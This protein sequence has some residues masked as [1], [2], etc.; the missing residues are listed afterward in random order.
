MQSHE[1][2]LRIKKYTFGDLPAAF[3][4]KV[5]TASPTGQEIAHWHSQVELIRVLDGHIHCH[6]NHSEFRLGP[7][8][9]CFINLGQL[10]RVYNTE[11]Q[12]CA[13]EVLAVSP[14]LLSQNQKV[15]DAYISPVISDGSCGSGGR[16][17]SRR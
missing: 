10:H 13:L 3:E 1:K 15:F 4:H 8:E 11:A 6:V 17:A 2:A 14:E 16:T 9:F 7:G 12:P 5:V